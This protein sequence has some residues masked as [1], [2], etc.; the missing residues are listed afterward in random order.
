MIRYDPWWNPAA[1]RQATDRA[2]RIGQQSP[3]F[4]YKLISADT[5][6]ERIQALQE[7]K[8]ALADGLHDS[9]GGANPQWTEENVEELFKPLS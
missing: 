9:G 4:V 2:H 1:E 5:V 6:E 7:R 3:V 8:Q